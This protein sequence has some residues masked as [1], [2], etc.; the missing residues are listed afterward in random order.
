[1]ATFGYT[2][3]GGMQT[4]LASGVSFTNAALFNGGPTAGTLQSIS[5]YTKT[6]TATLNFQVALY[7]A[8]GTQTLIGSS[9]TQTATTVD[10]WI[11]ASV[12]G[13]LNDP[14]GDYYIAFDSSINQNLYYNYDAPT[15]G[16][17]ISDVSGQYYNAWPTTVSFSDLNNEKISI[18]FTYIPASGVSSEFLPYSRVGQ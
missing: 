16:E 8:T 17:N 13:T 9:S 2:T 7:N 11:T 6:N 15:N 1:M 10:Q 3:I 4:Q 18:Y 5:F 14:N 12:S